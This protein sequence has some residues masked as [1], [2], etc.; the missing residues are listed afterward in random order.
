MIF[1]RK[2]PAC[3]VSLS[4]CVFVCC[5][6]CVYRYVGVS[7]TLR[8]ARSVGA[9]IFLSSRLESETV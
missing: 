1:P 4:L 8:M 3:P 7:V 2:E 5:C 6:C 9:R